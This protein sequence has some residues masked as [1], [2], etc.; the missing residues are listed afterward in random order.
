MLNGK[1]KKYSYQK[2]SLKLNKNQNKFRN[3]STN[4]FFIKDLYNKVLPKLNLQNNNNDPKLTESNLKSSLASTF[5]S[6]NEKKQKPKLITEYNFKNKNKVIYK[7]VIN[8]QMSYLKKKKNLEINPTYFDIKKTKN[9]NNDIDLYIKEDYENLNI[10]RDNEYSNL[11]KKLD[12]WDEDNCLVKSNDK[13]ILYNNL[14]KFYKKKSM[15]QELKNLNTMESL[16]KS[17]TNYDKLLKD[18]L[19]YKNNKINSDILV[20]KNGKDHKNLFN[21]N[22]KRNERNRKAE[23]NKFQFETDDLRL[24]S[25]KIKY[26][27]QLHNDLIF[28][29][30]ILYNKKLLKTENLKRLEELYKT[31]AELKNAYDKNYNYNMK[32]YWSRYDE[33]EHRYKKL[34]NLIT[35]QSKKD[36]EN[37]ENDKENLNENDKEE[38]IDNNQIKDE[39]EK[40]N[41]ETLEK[42]DNSTDEN[43]IRNKN[44]K[45]HYTSLSPRKKSNRKVATNTDVGIKRTHNRKLSS[46]QTKFMKEMN[47]IK[48]TKIN[49]INFEM[50][51][52][53]E[54]LRLDYQK[55]IKEIDEI[56]VNLEEEIKINKNEISYYKQVNEELIKEYRNYYLKILKK[57][58]DHRKEGLV[59]VVKNLLE[60]QINLEYQHFPKYLTHEQ[61]D[62]LIELAH[63]LLEQSELIIIIKVLRKKQ[64]TTY[65]D[66]NIQ[67]YNMLDK[68]MEEHIKEKNITGN[69]K[70]KSL[71]GDKNIYEKNMYAIID[72]IDKKFDKVYKNNKEI[73]KHYLEKNEEDVKLRNA[74]EH[75]KKGLYN[76]DKF[77][78]ENQASILDA[79]IGNSKNKDFFS[80]ILNIRNRLNQ[81]EVIITNLIKKEKDYYIEQIQK[82]N[83]ATKNF[84]INFYKE[85]IKKSLFGEK[86]ELYE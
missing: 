22:Y 21:H 38:E 45:F 35:S 19:D 76:S 42:M 68:Y 57:G 1:T 55:K 13:I 15:F 44:R 85:V 20:P 86:F 5:Y 50:K 59:W 69:N 66:E 83:S 41:K 7:Y 29:N 8:K 73:V 34:E 80:F 14:N 70:R 36:L 23:I 40:N 52:K 46:S 82:Y 77:I 25:E 11:I 53:M 4:H 3:N 58:N 47:F 16:L 39:E 2:E 67:A 61:I 62:Y 18:R 48:A 24:L 32:D 71:M 10:N 26:E 72:E 54:R 75:I 12:R 31:R 37:E 56:Q 43:N 17:K 74:L 60:L 30:S 51:K 33:Y 28:V 84:D 65:I 9:N 79:F 78:K 63:L 49:T 64:T 81:L 6:T 27:T